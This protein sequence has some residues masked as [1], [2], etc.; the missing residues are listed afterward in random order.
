MNLLH[1]ATTWT[2]LFKTS[3]YRGS[4]LQPAA[5]WEFLVA[6]AEATL[7]AAAGVSE[8]PWVDGRGASELL[9]AC[10]LLLSL[11]LSL[12]KGR[13]C[14]RVCD[15]IWPISFCCSLRKTLRVYQAPP[16][17]PRAYP[18]T[19]VVNA[20]A[21]QAGVLILLEVTIFFISSC[22]TL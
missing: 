4:Q 3:C 12:L 22:S 19:E 2:V 17:H 15:F 9:E 18:T 5:A 14:H 11:V 6:F 16:R 7:L 1:F 21:I 20:V 8:A 10:R 13:H